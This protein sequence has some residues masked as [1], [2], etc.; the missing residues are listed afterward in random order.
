[1]RT[2]LKLLVIF[3]GFALGLLASQSQAHTELLKSNPVAGSTILQLPDR[4]ELT[5]SEPPIPAGSY[6]FL[7]QGGFIATHKLVGTAIGSK[8]VFEWPSILKPGEVNVNWRAVAQDGHVESDR[9]SF[10]YQRSGVSDS[11]KPQN[12]EEGTTSKLVTWAGLF[13]LLTLVAGVFYTSR[14]SD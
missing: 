10:T 14:R 11:A 13:M 9:F 4:L 6:V 7:E 2:R 3:L 5:F 1:M 8:L 12:K